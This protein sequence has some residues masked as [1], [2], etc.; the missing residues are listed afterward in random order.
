[1]ASDYGM[2]LAYFLGHKK[3]QGKRRV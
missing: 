2:Q 3:K 1:L